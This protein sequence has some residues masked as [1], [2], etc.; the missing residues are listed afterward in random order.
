M[1]TPEV[2]VMAKETPVANGE[3]PVVKSKYGE[4]PEC[5]SSTIQ[6]V[7]FVL[8]CTMAIGINSFLAGLVTVITSFIAEDLDMATAEITWISAAAS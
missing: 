6:E 4:R 5:F 2:A 8:T 3:P 7:L 1:R